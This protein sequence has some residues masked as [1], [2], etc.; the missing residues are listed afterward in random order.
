[1]Q[2]VL[3]ILYY[4]YVLFFGVY[5]SLRLA[6]GQF[7]ARQWRLFS[8]LC[9][10]L[11]LLQG[12][13]LQIFGM[14][15]VWLIYPLIAHAPIVLHLRFYEKKTWSAALISVVISYSTC[16]LLRW[17]G[18][19]LDAFALIPTAKL[20]IHLAMCHLFLLLLDR[21]CL[22]AM[23]GALSRSPTLLSWFS[24]LPLLYYL[25]DYFM[26]YTN[27]RFGHIL[28]FSELLPTEMVLFFVLFARAYQQETE[29]REKSEYQAETL[30]MELNHAEREISSLRAT[31]ERTAIYRHD[32]RHHLTLVGSMI[33]ASQTEQAAQYI[34]SAVSEI[35][36]IAPERFCENE[37]MNLI[38]S[39]YKAKAAEKSVPMTIRTSF[40]RAPD[41]PDTELCAL[42]SNG[43]E[44]ALNATAALPQG[45]EP[46]IEV[47][48]G[49]KQNNLLIEIKN[50]HA[51]NII[52]QN[53]IPC[54]DDPSHYGCRSIQSIAQRRNGVCSFESAQNVFLLR[55]AIPL[56]PE[57]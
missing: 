37:T 25:Y 1:M 47:F 23:H 24:A 41:L 13:C 17:F 7:S 32:L 39:A 49:T 33:A 11:L 12:V 19:V 46:K 57:K 30:G 34:K 50:P 31:Q 8:L 55:V 20:I 3:D 44:N 16:Q 40:G 26:L 4:I 15:R 45:S 18:L 10:A 38:L 27:Q 56:G 28:A 5:I 6:C 29:R 53:G 52:L 21:T 2:I 9:P 48:C 42:L 14:E 36:S 43:L 35:E 22:S 51:G 54:A